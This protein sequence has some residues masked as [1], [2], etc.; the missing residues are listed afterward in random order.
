MTGERQGAAIW[1]IAAAQ[2]LDQVRRL[3]PNATEEAVR[4]FRDEIAAAATRLSVAGV[5]VADP[6]PVSFTPTWREE[7]NA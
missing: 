2:L 5:D 7:V 3:D 4:R 1:G 6:L